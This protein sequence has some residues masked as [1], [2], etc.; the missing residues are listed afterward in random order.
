MKS[1]SHKFLAL[2][3]IGLCISFTG[4]IEINTRYAY[5]K[6]GSVIIKEE[7]VLTRRLLDF[8]DKAGKSLLLKHIEKAACEERAKLYGPGTT[9][10]SHKIKKIPGGATVLNAEYK[11]ADMAKVF[12]VSPFV[13]FTNYKDTRMAKFRVKPMYK[14]DAYGAKAGQI[15]LRIMSLK[16]GIGMKRPVKDGPPILPPDPAFLQNYR[17]LQPIFKDLLKD[18]KVSV[19][20]ESYASVYTGYGYR[21]RGSQPKKCEILSF[22]G[23][24]Y[25]KFGVSILDNDEIMHELLRHE[26]GEK[27]IIGTVAQFSRNKTVPVMIMNGSRHA[28]WGVRPYIALHPSRILFDK[29][30]KGKSLNYNAWGVRKTDKLIPAK[31]ENIGFDRGRKKKETKKEVP[32]EKKPEKTPA[33]KP[34][35]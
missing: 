33:K 13:S 17:D 24:D 30:F 4:C 15:E 11:N 27:N 35:K 3:L 19:I 8:K 10:I 22:S 9:V 14:S 2:I 5:Q 29:Y 31:Y 20:F 23:K 25:D 32:P 1:L 18:F 16:K 12:L 7:V 21:G 28:R 6:D 34:K 26:F